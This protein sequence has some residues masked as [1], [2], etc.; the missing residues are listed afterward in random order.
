M[1]DVL[2]KRLLVIFML[3]FSSTLVKSQPLAF[4]GA[5][6]CGRFATGG[7]GGKVVFITN[8][9]DSGK[10]SL[11][12]ALNNYDVPR[13]ILFSV[14]GTIFLKSTIE[15]SSGNLTLAGQS[16]PGDGICIAGAGLDI[17]ADNVIIRYMRFRPGEIDSIETDALTIKRSHNVIVDHCSMSWSTDETCSCYDN[18]DFTLQWCIIS[19]SLNK[20]VHH[21]GEHGYG[22]I[23]GGQN[24]TF[25][26]NLLAHHNSRNPRLNGSRYLKQPEKEKAELI[27]NVVYNWKSKCIYAGEQG[28]YTIT[29]NY[30]KPG[31]ATGKPSSKRILDPWEPFSYYYFNSNF[32]DGN[33][34]LTANNKLSIDKKHQL[35][36][37]FF[38]KVP[39][40]I[41]DLAPS[42]AHEAFSAVLKSAGASLHRDAVDVRIIDEV[43][44]GKFTYGENGIINS[45][46]DVGG[47]PELKTAPAL[48]DSDKDGM[49]DE[50]ELNNKLNPNNPRDGS[51]INEGN[52]YSNLEIYLNEIESKIE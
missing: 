49:A 17:E 15:I 19:E 24:A 25:H 5:E 21:K 2:F 4:P 27:N 6:G 35:P 37:D 7:R 8:L 32:I 48:P 12:E 46:K 52:D 43:R 23:W 41:S 38:C 44:H 11:R 33:P 47:W 26:H 20:S 14:S 31:P 42:T 30:F 36:N 9:N 1:L 34:E 50:W 29:E 40:Q 18:Y 45:Q 28:T 13:T 51:V 16:A 39:L 22:G 10:G 3:T